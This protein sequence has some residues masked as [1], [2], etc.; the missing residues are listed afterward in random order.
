MTTNAT[1]TN[2]TNLMTSK[3]FLDPHDILKVIDFQQL[4][5]AA[6]AIEA[7]RANLL[8]AA[9]LDNLISNTTGMQEG[10]ESMPRQ[11]VVTGYDETGKP[12]TKYLQAKTQDELND[13]IVREYISSG[14][15]AEFIQGQGKQA[16]KT[17]FKQYAQKWLGT[18]S[19]KADNTKRNYKDIIEKQLIPVFGQI[20]IEDITVDTVQNFLDE[21]AK[22]AKATVKLTMVVLKGILDLAIE[23][24]II[25][26]NPAKSKT[27]VIRAVREN[28]RTALSDEQ[29]QS[30]VNEI[31]KLTPQCRCIV[32]LLMTTALRK[33]E[34]CALKWSDIDFEKNIVH[35][36]RQYD[37]RNGKKIKPPKNGSRGEVGI[38][39]WAKEVLLKNSNGETYVLECRRGKPISPGTYENRIKEI[40]KTIELYG[41]SSHVFRHSAI[42]KFYHSTKDVSNTQGFARHKNVMTTMKIYVD[43]EK[44]KVLKSGTYFEGL[45]TYANDQGNMQR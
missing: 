28:K 15:I 13:R 41:A 8:E 26:T 21:N 33:N 31:H 18:K 29:M 19:E 30:I 45:Y 9:N 12:I 42:T 16:K 44:E 22:Y 24:R 3:T 35:I 6:E 2:Q 36:E 32:A 20:S 10:N 25:E 38:P 14:R 34:L 37:Y 5:K 7:V 23:N 4:A 1:Q 27:L 43:P 17:D 39:E 40:R 11:R